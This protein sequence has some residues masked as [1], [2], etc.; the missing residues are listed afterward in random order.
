MNKISFL[1]PAYNCEKSINDTVRAAID[2]ISKL[3]YNI[4]IIIVDDFSCDSTLEKIKRIKKKYDFVKIIKNSK[5]LGFAL[6]ILKT[7]DYVTGDYIKALHAGNIENSNQILSLLKAINQNDF[8]LTDPVD[9]RSFFR[10]SLSRICSKILCIVSNK[11]IK[12]FNSGLVCKTNLFKKFY[13]EGNLYGNFTISLLVAKLL[14]FKYKYVEVK[15]NY[16]H[17]LKSSNSLKFSNLLSFI[18][19][20]M[21][22]LKVRLKNYFFN[23]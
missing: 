15:V 18:S 17:P 10:R 9:N 21:I 7:L 23:Y 2:A 11:N 4:E 1:I 6:S 19:V 5:N 20:I 14:I 16:R 12:Y 13:T 3:Q 22:I 8:I